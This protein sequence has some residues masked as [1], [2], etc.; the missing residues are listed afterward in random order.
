MLKI[1]LPLIILVLAIFFIYQTWSNYQVS[2]QNLAL[3]Q[4][5]MSDNAQR[6]EIMTTQSGLQYEVLQAGTGNRHPTTDSKVEVHYEGRLL[7]GTVFDS[8]YQR[9]QSI[10]FALNQVIKGWQEGVQLMV[11]G[12]KARFYIPANLA[13]GKSGASAIPPSATLIFDVELIRID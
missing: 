1:L 5:F 9:N 12:E 8:S 6:P 3:G 4:A 11:E 10:R 13:Y 7:D 2:K